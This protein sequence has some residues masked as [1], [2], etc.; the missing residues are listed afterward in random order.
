MGKIMAQSKTQCTLLR[1]AMPLLSRSV[2]PAPSFRRFATT[3]TDS[4]N[5]VLKHTD[6]DNNVKGKEEEEE[7]MFED[8][9]DVETLT[10][11]QV[12]ASWLSESSNGQ[13]ILATAF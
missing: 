3:T 11:D 9:Y 1:R 4:P 5:S 2:R 12:R 7:E 10:L 8:S 13:N 6:S